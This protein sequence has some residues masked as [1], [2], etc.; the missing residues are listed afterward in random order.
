MAKTCA[1][2][3]K[4]W[5]VSESRQLL[6]LNLPALSESQVSCV[7]PLGWEGCRI[8]IRRYGQ[9]GMNFEDKHRPF[10]II[11]NLKHQVGPPIKVSH[12]TAHASRSCRVSVGP[13]VSPTT[14]PPT[15]FFFSFFLF[16]SFIFP[17][18]FSYPLSPAQRRSVGC[19]RVLLRR[20]GEKGILSA[21][22]YQ[23]MQRALGTRGKQTASPMTVSSRRSNSQSS[24]SILAGAI[25]L[26][27]GA[28]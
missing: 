24:R 20:W 16:L 28:R 9:V 7:S 5:H 6:G 18:L 14:D 13:N 27:G 12:Q 8:S 15:S 3:P 17:S 2:P 25:R 26:T 11:S 4:L 10:N 21:E 19:K 1:S 23:S 22:G